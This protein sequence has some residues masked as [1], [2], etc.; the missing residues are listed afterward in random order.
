[1]IIG[2][3]GGI[4]SGK[5]LSVV[6]EIVNKDIFAFTNFN[7]N[8]KNYHRLR[9]SDILKFDEKGK[10]IN[11]NW[12]Y[13]NNIN[14]KYKNYSIFLDEIGNICSS[15]QS[16]S[17]RNILINKW[18]SQIRKVLQDNP[19][20]HLYFITQK[21]RQV[22]IIF[23]ELAQVIIRCKLYKVGTNTYIKQ[24]Y[25]DGLEQYALNNPTAK[26]F[27]LGNP[28]FKYYNRKEMVTFGD[29]ENYI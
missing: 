8:V 13:W 16:M 10:P 2:Y 22:D 4:G 19:N 23:R 29:E 12:K 18:L 9:L 3:T 11:I 25:Y 17:K 6:K 20:N 28:Y 24:Y 5:T 15:R 27:Y 26:K 14:R 1:M 7:L 21:L